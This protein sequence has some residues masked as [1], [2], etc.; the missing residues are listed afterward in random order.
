MT[1][2]SSA[3]GRFLRTGNTPRR[4]QA[5]DD[6]LLYVLSK[7]HLDELLRDAPRVAL[8]FA[9]DF[10][11]DIPRPTGEQSARGGASRAASR[12]GSGH[13]AMTCVAWSPC[14]T[15]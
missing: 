12:E 5:K 13:Q 1:A 8:F 9:A 4:T 11:A 2:T 14:A 3:C 6:T 7:A 15:C 10:A